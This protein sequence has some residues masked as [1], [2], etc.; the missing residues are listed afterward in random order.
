VALYDAIGREYAKLRRA[1]SRIEHQI[2]DALGDAARVVNVGAGAGSYEPWDRFVVAVEPSTTMI[3][4]RPPGSAPVVQASA[5]ALP[6]RDAA[7][8]ASL[9]ILTIHHW[10][11]WRRGVNELARTTKKRIVILTWDPSLPTFWLVNDYF[12]EILA[13]DRVIFP[14]VD[15][16]RQEL[17]PLRITAVP[18]PH[19]CTDGLLGAYWRRPE[20][21]L[22][23]SV[24]EAIS[25]FNKLSDVETGLRKL[26]ADLGSGVWQR[27]N[28]ALF[29]SDT[30]DLGYRLIVS[31]VRA[32]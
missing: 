31:N 8:D 30:L 4:Q 1:D 3:A 23:T 6:F 13:S 14:S 16:L 20:E 25:A 26:R 28:R 9:A 2:V 29:D 7:F 22:E 27:R 21:Y 18:I 11:D 19:D 12:P 5:E 32:A 15:D 17:G 24:R 10:A